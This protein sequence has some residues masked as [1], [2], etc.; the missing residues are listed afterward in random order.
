MLQ[1]QAK[2]FA[3]V[4]CFGLF[5]GTRLGRAW[6]KVVSGGG[7]AF[8]F[9]RRNM[10]VIRRTVS[11]IRRFGMDIRRLGGLDRIWVRFA[12]ENR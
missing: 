4:F 3:W 6:V 12:G 9:I 11:D 2:K 8:D 10:G 7:R 1:T 5:G